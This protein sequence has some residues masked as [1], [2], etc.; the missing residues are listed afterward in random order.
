MVIAPPGFFLTL[1]V[2]SKVAEELPVNSSAARTNL[3]RFASQL[4]FSA[5][6]GVAEPVPRPRPAARRAV[7]RVGKLAALERQA[8]ATD[9]LGEPGLQALE[10]GETLLDARRPLARQAGPVA[11]PR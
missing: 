4:R 7:A 9:A 5:P 8:A 6:P 3:Q 1:C 11:P 2:W 10:L